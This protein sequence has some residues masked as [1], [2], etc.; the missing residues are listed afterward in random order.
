MDDRTSSGT[1]AFE[2]LAPWGWDSALE[3]AFAPH[4]G[5]GPVPGRVIVEDGGAWLV[6]TAEHELVAGLS[7]RY[8]HELGD[9]PLAY[10]AVGDWVVVEAADGTAQIIDRLPR[11]TVVVRRAPGGRGRNAQVVG[12][13][14]DLL[15]LVMSLNRDFNLRRLERYVVVAWESGATPMILLSKSDLTADVDSRVIGAESVAP[16]V[17]VVPVS[18]VT[19]VGIAE[20]RERIVDGRTAA[21]IGSSG[22]GKSTIVNVLAGVEVMAAAE[23]RED[24]ARG[25]HTTS[26]RQLIQLGQGL[27]LDTPGMREL[28]LSDADGLDMAF[29]DVVALAQGCRFRDCEHHSEPGCAVRAAILAGE[30]RGARLAS[31]ERL[32]REAR[33]AQ[34]RSDALVRLAEGRRW[35]T[36]SK[37]NRARSKALDRSWA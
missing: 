29:T 20:V 9:D 1:Q 4:L 35:K 10:P 28:G 17:S 37:N 13:N 8:R 7:G 36:I 27:V 32:E 25:R 21:F 3:T 22:V 6:R 16:G 23:I 33:S 30:L 12:A 14:V 5:R 15:F 19:G 18:A 24:D 31:Y 26:R 34:R 2:A 11:R